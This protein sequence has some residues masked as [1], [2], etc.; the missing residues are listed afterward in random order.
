MSTSLMPSILSQS[1]PRTPTH[2]PSIRSVSGKSEYAG[3]MGGGSHALGGGG[4][5]PRPPCMSPM[6]SLFGRAVEAAVETVLFAEL[7]GAL[8]SS[9]F[10]AVSVEGK[11]EG[12]E[13]CKEKEVTLVGGGGGKEE[14]KEEHWP[15]PYSRPVRA[16]KVHW[17]AERDEQVC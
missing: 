16:S 17:Q 12:K 14:P 10:L 7:G 5:S 8:A 11:E 3:S 9:L 6:S 13:E 2:S 1:S 4:G 15:S